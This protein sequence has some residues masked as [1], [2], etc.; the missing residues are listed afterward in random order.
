[1]REAAPDPS[2]QYADSDFEDEF[3]D[4]DSRYSRKMLS[5]IIRSDFELEF[6]TSTNAKRASQRLENRC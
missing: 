2:N 1:M 5:H 3:D 4:P 6:L